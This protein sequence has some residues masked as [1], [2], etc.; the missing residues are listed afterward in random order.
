MTRRNVAVLERILPRHHK[1]MHKVN[2]TSHQDFQE[3]TNGKGDKR[4]EDTSTLK[5]SKKASGIE[6]DMSRRS[7]LGIQE[8]CQEA[9]ELKDGKI[10]QIK[11][12]TIVLEVET[13]GRA[14][15]T[16]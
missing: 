2:K 4:R 10:V 14:L 12:G 9:D 8:I 3:G 1:E 5:D 13:D 16:E 6:E 11:V 7:T 15:N